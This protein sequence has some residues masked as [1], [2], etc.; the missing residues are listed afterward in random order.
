MLWAGIACAAQGNKTFAILQFKLNAPPDR[1]Y[2]QEGMRDMLGS[3]ITAET[4][5]IIVPKI[6]V[7]NAFREVGGDLVPRD[8]ASF[9]RNAGA[10]Y[11]V[12]GTITALGGGI[13]IDA[14]VY[15]ASLEGGQAVQSFY[16]S[17]TANEQ[18]MQTIDSLAWDIVE[19]FFA[20]K[21]P[22]SLAAAPAQ[23][24]AGSG[25]ESSSF[26]TA[27]PD[28]TFMASGG[29]FSVRGSRNFV[30]TRTFDMDL[31]GMDICD[32]DGDGQEEIVLGGRSEVQ[33]FKR[34]G[35][36]LNII[37]TI[38]MGNRYQV[39]N[40]NCADLNGNGRDEIY[41]SAADPKLPGSS[42]VEWDGTKFVRLFNEARWYIKPVEIPDMGLVLVGQTTGLL[43]VEPGLYHLTLTGNVLERQERLPIPAEVN[44]FNFAYADLDGDGKHEIVALDNSFKLMVYQGGTMVWR[45]QERFG[46]TRRFLGGYPDMKAGTRPLRSDI[47]DGI[48]DQYQET[49]VPSRIIVSD[50]DND[51]NDDLIINRNP[52]T[53]TTVAPRLVQYPNGTLVGLKWNGIGLEEIWRT[54]KIDGYVI[55]YE[56]KSSALELKSD[57]ED[58]LFIGLVL[59]SG[60]FESLLSNKSTVVIYPFEFEMPEQDNQ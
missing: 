41:I 22:A 58:E 40:V 8:L 25:G 57:V 19:T 32:V 59:N 50:V 16:G 45:S 4:G 18:I 47:V 5:S 28:K 46:G 1:Q 38:D 10:D 39:H 3:R 34:D 31:R 37:D 29:G 33:V 13:S 43:P 26:T 7:D 35:T 24:P 48:G 14:N 42:A 44:L 17:A 30:R 6:K 9:A 12:F 51:G 60:T 55:E 56:V 23:Q 53:L 36:R 54:R 20:K 21:R 11:L 52:D 27:H 15:D 49:Y 2:L